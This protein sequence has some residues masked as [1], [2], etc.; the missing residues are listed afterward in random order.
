MPEVKKTSLN[1]RD[2]LPPGPGPG[3]PK[4][5]SNKTTR[6]LKEATILAAE[7][8]GNGKAGRKA[9][10][11]LIEFLKVQAAKENNAPFMALLRQILPL[12]IANAEGESF[13]TD[14]T[15][16]IEFVRARSDTDT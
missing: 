7:A 3:R 2:R 16:K 5:L 10:A 9:K 1:P 4:G 11:G 13:Q 12:Q 15:F 8:V 14:N 6:V